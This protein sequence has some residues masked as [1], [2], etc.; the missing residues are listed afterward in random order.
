MFWA[1]YCIDIVM[2]NNTPS[3]P[4]FVRPEDLAVTL[5][6]ISALCLA[7]EAHN[8]LFP[9]KSN[10]AIMELQFIKTRYKKSW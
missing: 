8:Q 2:W 3:L 7:R 4:G 10:N 6:M 9:W 5:V 1:Q